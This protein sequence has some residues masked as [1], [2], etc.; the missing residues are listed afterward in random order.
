[1]RTTAPE[2]LILSYRNCVLDYAAANDQSFQRTT[3]DSRPRLRLALQGA[4][5]AV[6][7]LYVYLEAGATSGLDTHY[8]AVKLSNTTGLNLAAIA[9]TGQPLAIQGL[10]ALGNQTSTVPLTVQVPRAGSYTLAVGELINF[11]AGTILVLHDQLLNLATP[12]TP[13]AHYAFQA[14]DLTAAG[15]FYLEL[16]AQSTLATTTAQALVEQVQVYPNPAKDRFQVQVPAKFNAATLTLY[17]SLGKLVR[18]QQ[19]TGTPATLEVTDL[20]RGV[21][22]LRVQAGN[23]LATKR[24]TLD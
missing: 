13:T 12:L 4:G 11:A 14:T 20:A 3:A 16:R 22:L 24:I 17:N 6:D 9:S 23:T 18:T 21:Y 7:D 15:R 5:S 8:D 19:I 1:V 10:A 2:T